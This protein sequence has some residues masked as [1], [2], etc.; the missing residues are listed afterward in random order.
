MKE[1]S[2]KY[3]HQKQ[4]ILDGT[5]GVC[6]D[7]NGKGVPLAMFL[8]SAP[9]GNKAMQAGYDIKIR[10]QLLNEWR[11]SLGFQNGEAFKLLVAITDMDTKERDTLTLIWPDI[12]L[13]LCKFH[14]QQ[15][16]T[17]RHK[18]VLPMGQMVNFPKQQVQARLHTLEDWHF[19]SLEHD[20]ALALVEE[21]KQV[22]NSLKQQPGMSTA[23]TA[24]LSFLKY[25]T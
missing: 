12:W 9:T 20:A 23:A 22:L 2:W 14:I 4:V 8:F 17:N 1:V 21:E 6:V 11:D 15:C 19:A 24:G 25:L 3:A 16:W 18:K 10:Y 5:F 13:L 7:E